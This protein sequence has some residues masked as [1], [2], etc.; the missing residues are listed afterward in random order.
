MV[1]DQFIEK[2]PLKIENYKDIKIISSFI[3]NNVFNF[4]IEYSCSDQNIKNIFENVM[5]EIAGRPL[6][7][8]IELKPIYLK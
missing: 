7:F 4:D 2:I 5:E 3:T 8:I 1:M 6:K